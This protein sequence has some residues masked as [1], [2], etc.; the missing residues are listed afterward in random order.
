LYRDC[1]EQHKSFHD[2]PRWINA[3]LTRIML[4]ERYNNERNIMQSLRQSVRI[5]GKIDKM[6]KS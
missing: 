3:T 6:A 4:N 1:H 5:Q 2:W